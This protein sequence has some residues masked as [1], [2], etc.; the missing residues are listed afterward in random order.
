MFMSRE[1]KDTEKKRE[2]CNQGGLPQIMTRVQP[3]M[4]ESPPPLACHMVAL[5]CSRRRTRTSQWQV[6]AIC[7][8]IWTKIT[9][10]LNKF[11]K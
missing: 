6:A 10:S 3:G 11:K 9:Q 7:S 1:S 4:Q 2:R 5:L 8:A